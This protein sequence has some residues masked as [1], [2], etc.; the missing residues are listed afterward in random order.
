MGRTASVR[1]IAIELRSA[2]EFLT[3]LAEQR[4]RPLRWAAS[5]LVEREDVRVMRPRHNVDLPQEPLRSGP[6]AAASSCPL[7]ESDVREVRL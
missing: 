7:P 2:S 1:A 4:G 3:W 6:G 5:S